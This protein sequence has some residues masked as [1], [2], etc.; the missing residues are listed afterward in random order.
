MAATDTTTAD[1]L[2][3]LEVDTLPRPGSREVQLQRPPGK[4]PWQLLVAAVVCVPCTLLFALLVRSGFGPAAAGPGPPPRMRVDNVLLLDDAADA[5]AAPGSSSDAPP[6]GAAGP[7]GALPPGLEF[8]FVRH[9]QTTINQQYHKFDRL[10]RVACGTAND[11]SPAEIA[12]VRLPWRL[13]EAVCS[14]TG[15]LASDIYLRAAHANG[16]AGNPYPQAYADAA[17]KF[18]RVRE[19]FDATL[20][21]L[22][23]L[24]AKNLRKKTRALQ[25]AW[26]REHARAP[27]DGGHRHQTF[28]LSSNNI[29]AV[30]TMLTGMQGLA[31]NST[32]PVILHTTLQEFGV[33]GNGAHVALFLPLA[34]AENYSS[35]AN[36]KV[37]KNVARR[38]W[39]GYKNAD[40]ESPGV[41][42]AAWAPRKKLVDVM[43][44]KRQHFQ[45]GQCGS[46]QLLAGSLVNHCY[47][48]PSRYIS[49]AP[50]HREPPPGPL[51]TVRLPHEYEPG[52]GDGPATDSQELGTERAKYFLAWLRRLH[53]S[54]GALKRVVVTG[55]SSW[56]KRFASY[57]QQLGGLDD[58]SC[59]GLGVATLRNTAVLKIVDGKCFCLFDGSNLGGK[60]TSNR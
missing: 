57:M 34:L 7:P 50:G 31:T 24:Q 14:E 58:A 18:L 30:D 49:E 5:P 46:S 47:Y 28:L 43:W 15:K 42:K 35:L 25:R 59:A 10:T 33:S 21:G 26:L 56:F 13:R 3:S 41:L 55:H 22:G 40:D 20:T 17:E 32:M 16:T 4:R 19:W 6:P 2:A 53:A 38:R 36:N 27:P 52:L 44:W 60:C 45:L 48:L 8:I 54:Q 9:G 39:L 51:E 11:S 23:V 12:S 29:R 37:W 1:H